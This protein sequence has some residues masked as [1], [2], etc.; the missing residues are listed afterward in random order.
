[1]ITAQ[2]HGMGIILITL[3][4]S[5]L[6][7]LLPLPEWAR[8]FRPQWYTMALIYWCM[9]HPERIGVGAGWL[10]G[11][12]VD[13]MT[14]SLLGQHALSLSIVAFI[15]VKLHKRI[16]VYPLWQQSFVVL[17]LLFLEPFVATWVMGITHQ[18]PPTS[19][20]WMAPLISMLLWPWVFIIL[21]DVR[22]R[23]HIK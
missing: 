12:T 1:M 20:F 21:R 16:R 19:H 11:L 22:R 6:F 23:F 15:V 3:L 5:L 14:E 13:V 18:P 17:I 8:P 7:T 9:A 4:A 10:L 2:K